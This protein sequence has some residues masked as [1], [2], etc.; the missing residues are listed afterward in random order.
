MPPVDPIQESPEDWLSRA[1]GAL[2]LA[3]QTKPDDAFWEDQCFLA[4]QAAER[5]LKAVHLRRNVTFRYTHDL[6]ELGK[7]LEN[8]GLTIPDLVKDAIILTRYAVETRYP[9]PVEPVTE[10]EYYEALRLAD[11]VV[12]WATQI[13]VQ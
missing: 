5:A 3:K 11:A 1:T 2:A 12:A 6:E 8:N 7:A 10:E 9:G 4:Q 13:I